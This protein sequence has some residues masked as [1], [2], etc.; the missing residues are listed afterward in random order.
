M[1]MCQMRYH[2]KPEQAKEIYKKYELYA[3]CTT[4]FTNFSTFAAILKHSIKESLK[5]SLVI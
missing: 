4:W 2:D 5:E 3:L 1:M